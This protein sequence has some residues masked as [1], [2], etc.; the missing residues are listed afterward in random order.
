MIPHLHFLPQRIKKAREAAQGHS[1]RI[2]R[3]HPHKK[4]FEGGNGVGTVSSAIP[5]LSVGG[6]GFGFH[7]T[8]LSEVEQRITKG[9]TK[10][11]LQLYCCGHQPL[12]H[13][14]FLFLQSHL[15]QLI[16]LGDFL[17]ENQQ[18]KVPKWQA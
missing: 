13:Q 18:Y 5:L 16:Y 12:F 7:I 8:S 3:L 17:R 14:Y 9:S 10:W 1:P 11:Q 6:T 4:G 15:K 2:K